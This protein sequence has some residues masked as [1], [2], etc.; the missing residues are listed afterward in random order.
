MP[1]IRASLNDGGA[2]AHE[3]TL[4]ATNRRGRPISCRVSI[5]PLIERPGAASQGAIVLMDEQADNDGG[6]PA[7]RDGAD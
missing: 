5:M 2:P 3:V 1:Q 7:P 6:R 4:P